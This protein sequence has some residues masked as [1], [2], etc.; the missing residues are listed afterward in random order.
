MALFS[1][2]KYE[3][4]P[5]AVISTCS[6]VVSIIVSGKLSNS[7]DTLLCAEGTKVAFQV[8]LLLEDVGGLE[9]DQVLL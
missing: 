4:G 7:S 9:K 5:K 8:H 2:Q 3:S 6:Q 1:N